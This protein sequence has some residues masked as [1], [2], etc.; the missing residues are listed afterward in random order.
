MNFYIKRLFRQ[1]HDFLLENYHIMAIVGGFTIF[2][3]MTYH[4][5]AH[6][7]TSKFKTLD[8]VLSKFS[9]HVAA[10][11]LQAVSAL[12]GLLTTF[13]TIFFY[14]PRTAYQDV[15]DLFGFR[16]RRKYL[17]VKFTKLLTECQEIQTL[18]GREENQS[19]DQLHIINEFLIQC[20]DKFRADADR[21]VTPTLEELFSDPQQFFDVEQDLQSFE[22]VFF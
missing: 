11:S 22:W 5:P 9:E 13:L 18:F 3:Y 21:I 8:Q 4:L 20:L 19:L 7:R 12:L 2:S 10:G 1:I 17:D 16:Q 6:I 14:L 15:Q